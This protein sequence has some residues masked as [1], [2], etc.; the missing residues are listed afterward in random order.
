MAAVCSPVEYLEELDTY[1]GEHELQQKGDE[2]DVTDGFYGDD[3]TLYDMLE[4]NEKE[5][6]PT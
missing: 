5:E 2:N 4:R 1:Y 3:N 6:K